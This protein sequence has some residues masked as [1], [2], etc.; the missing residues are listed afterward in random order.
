[1]TPVILALG[2]VLFVGAFVQSSIG[3]GINVVAAP[4]VLVV[5]PDLMPAAL[6]L[7]GFILPMVQFTRGPLDVAWRPLGWSLL[8]R[9]VTTP[10]GVWLVVILDR[11]WL[12]VIL[13]LTILLSVL[14]SVRTLAIRA[15]VG[16]SLVAGALSGISGATAAVGGPFT[17]LLFQN[18]PA[19]R[20]R[21][22]LAVS[23]LVGSAMSAV[24]LLVAGEMQLPHLVA[25]LVWVPFI[26]LGYAVSGRARRRLDSGAMRPVVLA[27]CTVAALVIMVRAF[28]A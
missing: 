19:Q 26:A 16:N 14:A 12:A 21:D 17:A 24:G 25:A 9:A 23:F 27:F 15:S 11:R 2:I 28:V 1:M 7:V 10:L 13:G 18:E 3:F 4:V 6:V 20:I 22:T 8:A 5:A